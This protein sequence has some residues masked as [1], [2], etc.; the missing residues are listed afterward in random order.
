VEAQGRR[1]KDRSG[2]LGVT[3]QLDL[4]EWIPVAV[5][6]MRGGQQSL[7]TAATEEPEAAS[8]DDGKGEKKE[9]STS[10]GKGDGAKKGDK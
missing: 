9:K 2:A 7:E 1:A 10:A 8:T 6:A 3:R 5:E 4:S